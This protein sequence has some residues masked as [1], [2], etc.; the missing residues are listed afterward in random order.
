MRSRL[1]TLSPV[2]L[3]GVQAAD[4]RAARQ[5]LL[6]NLFDNVSFAAVL[7]RIDAVPGGHAWVGHI[8]GIELSTV[9]LATVDGIMAGS[10]VMPN[11]VYAVRYVG[12]GAH[13]V[14]QVDQTR[15]P[16]EREPI[17]VSAPERAGLAAAARYTTS[18]DGAPIIDV[19][20][21]YTPAAAAAVGGDTAMAATINLGISE[22]NTSFVNSDIAQRLRLIHSQA[23]TYTEHDDLAADLYNLSNDDGYTTISTPLG[24][25]AASLR[26]TY[27]ADLVMLVTAPPSPDNCGIAWLMSSVSSGFEQYAFSVVEQSCISPSYVFAHELGHNMGARHDWYVD[28]GTTPH[29]YAHGYVN[30]VGNWRTVMAYNDQC[31]AQALDCTRLLYWSNPAV[32][33][34]SVPMG[35]AGGTRSNCPK[36]DLA[37]ADCDADD[38]LTLNK[39]AATVAGFRTITPVVTPVI[40]WANPAGIVYGTAL[41]AMQLNAVASVPGTFVYTPASGT[42]L[43]AGLGQTLS[44]TFTPEDT[45]NYTTATRTVAIDVTKA[46]PV[47]TWAAPASIVAFTPLSATQLNATADVSG[48]FVYSPPSGAVLNAGAGQTLAVTFTPADATNY[49]TVTE[50]V[51]IDVT[52]VTPVIT[53]ATPGS[54]VSG[55]ALSAAQLNASASVPGTFVYTPP[56]GTVLNTGMGQALSVAFTPADTINYTT[57]TR[58]VVIDVIQATPVITWANPAAIVHGTALSATQLNAT[59]DVAGTFVYDPPAGTVLAGGTGQ[60]LSVAFTPADAVAYT[61]ATGTVTIDVTWVPPVLTDVAPRGG[62]IGSGVTLTGTGFTAATAVTFHRV[63]SA[64][65]VVSDTEVLTSVPAGTTT[66]PVRVT[67]AGGTATSAADFTVTN[68]R[69]DRILPPCYV[70]GYGVTVSLDVGPAPDVLV[71]AQEDMPPAGWTAGTI[72][73]GGVFVAPTKTIRWG[74]FVDATARV[75]TYIVTPPAGTTGT[76]TFAGV[77]SF[78]GVEVP[79][80]GSQTLARCEQHPADAN[81]DFRLVI[82]EVTGYGAAWKRGDPW[83]TPPVPIPV[84]FMTRAGYLWRL[85]ETYRRD[86]GDCP[87]CWVPVPVPDALLSLE[88]IPAPRGGP[89][90][91]GASAGSDRLHQGYGGP[92]KLYAEAEAPAS[93]TRWNPGATTSSDT[94]SPGSLDPRS[95]GSLDPWSPGSLDSGAAAVRQVPATYAPTVPLVVTLTV[96]PDGDVQAWALEETV[97]AGWR[98]SAVSAD[99]YW[100]ETAGVVR[101]G[102][103]FDETP[104]TLR[105]TLTPPARAAGPQELRGTASFDGVD[106]I[107]TGVRTLQRAP[108]TR[109]GDPGDAA[110][111]VRNARRMKARDSG[112]SPESRAAGGAGRG[113]PPAAQAPQP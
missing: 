17:P 112:S 9:T 74:P 22:T 5:T 11:A 44:V 55:T 113:A 68:Q 53:W 37:N 105:Y 25:A 82:G 90:S 24:N 62:A 100:D 72:S 21:L 58:A 81:T 8:P 52:R 104:Q 45:I 98:V 107:V 69:A 47:V 40:T 50:A 36:G 111:S 80:G 97:P 30:T 28:N 15:F 32:L 38:H 10:I 79:V 78:D 27:S 65:T 14:A 23:I 61:T 71:Q 75:L 63:S 16:P 93:I 59:A 2:V 92:P 101:W 35:I 34:T 7:D 91:S 19:M 76:V 18:G 41:S 49:A 84:G 48:F 85:G 95:P 51:T 12:G 110:Q 77:V 70:P 73:D 6:L 88:D 4:R 87:V 60:V 89:W 66:G 46:M 102:P 29:T 106:E 26:N 39:T 20:V 3:Q 57:A 86:P 96:T 108:I 54:I 83:S 103:F 99:G 67:T 56:S 42:V 33:Y 64:Y 13:E 1:V 94:W 109:P 43:N 31:S